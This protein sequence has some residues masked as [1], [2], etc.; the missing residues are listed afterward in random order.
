MKIVDEA[1][2]QEIKASDAPFVLREF[3]LKSEI[4]GD[5]LE[6]HGSGVISRP[7]K[8]DFHITKSAKKAASMATVS[9]SF[10]IAS[11][12]SDDHLFAYMLNGW[13]VGVIACIGDNEGYQHV[14]AMACNPGLSACG[15][16]L[17]ERAVQ[18][19][20]E[21]GRDG[22]LSIFPTSSAVGKIYRSYGF[23]D[24]EVSVVEMTLDPATSL[25]WQ[26]LSSPSGL[27]YRLI[28]PLSYIG[29]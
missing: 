13:A 26:L 8:P 12:Q 24:S 20:M 25:K 21:N 17:I 5:S 15:G 11:R 28:P 16:A 27:R 29:D 22:K 4:F 19:S 6:E 3:A 14:E 2:I 1:P 23:I 18:L 10:L 7:D 9:E